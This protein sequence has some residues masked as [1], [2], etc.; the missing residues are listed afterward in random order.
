MPSPASSATFT[1]AGEFEENEVMAVY[2]SGSYSADLD[3]KTVSGFTI[4]YVQKDVAGSF[5][6]AAVPAIAYSTNNTLQFKNV[7]ALLKF[8]MGSSGVKNVTVWGDMKEV[9]GGEF[10][11]YYTE[12]NVYLT[13]DPQRNSDNARFAAYFW[14]SSSNKWVNMTEVS[15]QENT[16]TCAIPSGFDNV[17]FARM[18][19][20]PCL[21]V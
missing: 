12:G 3:E 10:P 15:G 13:V 11:D 1:Y 18:R 14:N 7:P 5:D 9:P 2:P 8:T 19:K 16:Y 4:P 17:L 20:I 6:P 21:T